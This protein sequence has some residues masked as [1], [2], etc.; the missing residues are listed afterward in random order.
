MSGARSLRSYCTDFKSCQATEAASGKEEGLV[1]G[2]LPSWIAARVADLSTL[3]A[4]F[5]VYT[6]KEMTME[7]RKT[8]PLPTPLDL[9]A[10]ITEIISSIANCR[11]SWE[12]HPGPLTVAEMV[13]IKERVTKYLAQLVD[14]YRREAR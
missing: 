7:R 6:I 1:R 14:D 8:M 10:Q 3:A 9:N 11:V 4:L 2:V 12:Q 13:A 5:A